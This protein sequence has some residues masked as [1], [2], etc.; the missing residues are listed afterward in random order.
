VPGLEFVATL[1][2]DAPALPPEYGYYQRLLA[3]DQSEAADLLEKHLKSEP[4]ETVYDSLLLPALNYAERD[5]LEL[6]LS[7]EEEAAV[8][9]GTKELIDDAHEWIPKAPSS[10]K[11][12]GPK[13]E[14]LPASELVPVL[15]Y[16]ANGP[17]DELA[18][19]MLQHLLEGSS[20]LLDI[21][22]GRSLASELVALVREGG[23]GIIC[24]ADLP[25]SAPS[26]T[27]YLV[28]K[29]RSAFPDVKVVVGRLA[30]PALA[31]E[32]ADELI[33]A[34]ANHVTSTLLDTR[35]RLLELAA[36]SGPAVTRP[37]N[38]A[39]P[40]QAQVLAR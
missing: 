29:L 34:G 19:R 12:E 8:I 31:D 9:E 14:A 3:R 20:L 5:R 40:P 6:R 10:A 30:P 26:K 23:Y 33:A 11:S 27:R 32:S 21:N 15:G 24:I 22:S 37:A 36:T 1:M 7:P 38:V 35:V 17:G 25:P 13:P 28:K 39:A 2:A 4:A 18:L 16:A